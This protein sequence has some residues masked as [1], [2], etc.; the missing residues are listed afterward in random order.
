M[1]EGEINAYNNIIKTVA[2]A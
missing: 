1:S 2:A